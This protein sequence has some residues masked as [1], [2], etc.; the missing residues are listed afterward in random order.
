[1]RLTEQEI[2]ERV[3]QSEEELSAY[4][5]MTRKWEAMWQLDAG[6]SKDWK[7]AI[8][9]DG[10]EQVTLPD[11]YNIINLA[12]R[13]ISNQP[14]ITI[15]PKSKA[16]ED[17]EAAEKMERWLMG[18]WQQANWQQNR[19]LI[20]DAAWQAFT[21]GSCIFEVKW[22]KDVLPKKLQGER[23]PI[24]IRTL[25]PREVGIKRGALYTEWAFHK[26][27]T[28][29]AT[30]KQRYPKLSKWR[31]TA[32]NYHKKI[33]NADSVAIT[34]FWYTD[35]NGDVWNAILVDDEF[36]KKPTKMPDYPYIPLIEGYGDSAPTGNETYKRMSLLHPLDGLWQYKCRLASNLGTGAL[37]GTWPFYLV[38]NEM[39]AE[40]PD[41]MVRPGATE[42]VP[43]GTKVDTVMPQVDIGKLQTTMQQIDGAMQQ[44]S[45]PGVMYGDS[46]GMQA[47]YG[48][49]LLS[50]AAA[51][52]VKNTRESLEMTLQSVNQLVL[53]MVDIAGGKKGV[54]LYALDKVQN[55][56]YTETLSKDEIKGYYRNIVT[57]TPDV[58]QDDMAKQSLAIQLFGNK[59]ISAQTLRDNYLP[60]IIPPDEESRIWTEQAQQTPEMAPRVMVLHFVD[61]F[62]GLV[63][64]ENGKETDEFMWQR[65]I[66]GTPM[67]GAARAMGLWP[68]EPKPPMPPPGPPGM[69]PPGAGGPPPGMPPPEGMGPPPGM[70]PPQGPPPEGMGGPPP[71]P[72]Q[73]QPDATLVGPQG[74]G[75]PPVMNA[76]ME[77][78][79]L[80]LPPNGDPRL[81]QQLMGRPLTPQE[82]LQLMA[83]QRGQG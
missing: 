40:V 55:R 14:K 78:E 32:A 81:F 57:L 43:A 69:P 62:P 54:E 11:P 51:G 23:F 41:F 9:Q 1:M 76:Q 35:G 49:N 4:R 68:E 64:D 53:A 75:I 29:V 74:G 46:G 3:A 28:D 27:E 56:A 71:G 20:A 44:A 10:R 15:P 25:D 12:M 8:E 5:G 30:A 83:Q 73:V 61:R 72:I 66:K 77:P 60:G 19:I 59:I 47:G 79:N 21:L 67:E 18:M 63:K 33:S 80:G 31:P 42:Q 7:R 48:V 52:R 39:G 16:I 37:W 17:N 82:E 36:H 70:M 26:Y 24:L 65:L 13:L 38:S 58:P 22:I 2:Q 6:F 50:A 34:D 45:F